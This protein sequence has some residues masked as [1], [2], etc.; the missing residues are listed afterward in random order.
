MGGALSNT[1][2]K[3]DKLGSQVDIPTTLLKQLD[4]PGNFPFGKDLLSPGSK[5]FAFYTFNEG[6]TF[7]T[8]SSVVSYDQKLR[9]PV[10]KEGKNPESAE[11]N[12]KAY[13]Q[14]LFN[15]YLKR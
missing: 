14:V 5:S 12:G 9:K 4:I 8:D 6:F 2:I 3:V 1:G 11:I 10:F 7:I 15:D 13:L